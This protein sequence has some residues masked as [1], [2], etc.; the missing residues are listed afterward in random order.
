MASTLRQNQRGES[1]RL[2][3]NPQTTP[4]SHRVDK[5]HGDRNLVC[6]RIG[7]EAYVEAQA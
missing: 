7:M 1:P 6:S 3:T 5:I 2:P 4:Q